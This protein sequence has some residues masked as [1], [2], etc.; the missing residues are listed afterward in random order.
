[1]KNEFIF[2]LTAL[3]LLTSIGFS[4]ETCSYNPHQIYFGPELLEVSVKTDIHHVHV[5]GHKHFGGF[6]LGYEYLK[7]WAFYAGIDF[8]STASSHHYA[9]SEKG[10]S[11]YSSDQST[12]FGNLDLRFGYAT[13]P[14]NLF[15]TPFLGAGVYNLGT[16]PHNRGFHEGWVYLSTGLRS[17][18][19]INPVFNLGINLKLFKSFFAY[20]QFQNHTTNITVY[21]YPWGAEIGIPFIWNFNPR[22]TWTFQIEPYWTK[23]DFSETQN[24]IGSKFLIEVHF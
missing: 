19:P 7:P 9:A 15:F 20:E 4:D 17:K 24:V 3:T 11:I 21:P 2:T 5:K 13:A 23:L 10:K 12:G 22:G 1:M 16:V 8:L 18:F 14:K 6:R